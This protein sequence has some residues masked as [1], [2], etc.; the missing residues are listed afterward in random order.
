MGF[1][2]AWLIHFEHFILF[3]ARDFDLKKAEAMLRD[4]SLSTIELQHEKTCLR[5]LRPVKKQTNLL[6]Y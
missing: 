4:V 2:A 3:S 1:L 5:G 6:S